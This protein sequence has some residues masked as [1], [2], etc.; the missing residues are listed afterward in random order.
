[1]EVL[2]TLNDEHF[3]TEL[4]RFN[5]EFNLDPMPFGDD[6][7]S[8]LE[9]SINEYMAKVRHAARQ[10]N[11]QV[12]L[13]G[14]LPTLQK[15]DLSL[16]NM[17]PM[18]RYAALNNALTSIRGGHYEFRFTGTDDL[19]I[20]HDTVMLESCNTSFQ[21]HFQVSA[22]EFSRF[23]NIAQAV[24]APILAAAVNSPLLF[25][26]RLW[27]ETRIALF[28]QAVDTRSASL[29]LQERK[30][31]VSFGTHWIK[32]SVVE[33]F[34]EDIARFRVILGREI[35]EDPFDMLDRGEV[36]KLDAL[37][38]HNG[39]VYRWTRP[40]Y[41]MTNGVP[42]LRIEN[43]ILPAGPTP[44]DEVANAAFWF[45]LI[46]GMLEE[47]GDITKV[48]DFD[49]AR[50]N[51]FA[52]A[53]RGLQAQFTWLDG[54]TITAQDLICKRLLP[55]ARN[56]L[57]QAQI[58]DSD[59]DL[60]LGIIEERIRAEQTG[61]EWLLK[62]LAHMKDRDNISE[63]LTAVTEATIRNQETGA[64]V[65]TWPLATLDDAGG[66]QKNYQR[67]D[68]YMTTDVFTVHEDETIDLVACL[69]DWAHIRHVPVEDDDG[70]LVGLVSYR[71]LLRALAQDL[72]RRSADPIPAR[73]IM[74]RDPIHIQPHTTTLDAID[75]MRRERVACLPV[76]D[77]HRLVGIITEHD[78]V[79]VASELLEE[80]LRQD[81]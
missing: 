12:V 57:K 75:T 78:F 27:K 16:D 6:C 73:D 32:D 25:G 68:Q 28:Q 45:G 47:Y 26:R 72:P 51:F 23:Y 38:L 37:Q 64:P 69:M 71:S 48:M 76:V 15:P 54:K 62:S 3:T 79:N 19:I 77:D 18:P 58:R 17:T 59:I 5:V 67:V 36:P 11:S 70:C 55:L 42:H 49:D 31:R 1:M 7:L 8:R 10:H 35:D 53:S 24:A 22:E 74:H 66:W 43:R 56:G 65:H 2:D 41:G 61:S 46:S 33:I 39:T 4:A 63:R 14:I 50:T 44:R 52:A 21:V 81:A 40:C 20:K 60:Y 30:A 34:Q 9:A 29:Q 80:R 13:T